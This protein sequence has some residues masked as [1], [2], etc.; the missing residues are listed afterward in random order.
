[1][2]LFDP[3]LAGQNHSVVEGTYSADTLGP[4]GDTAVYLGNGGLDTFI[5]TADA[6]E[7]F[8]INGD[9]QSGTSI[10]S[11][12]NTFTYVTDI[13]SIDV[14]ENASVT[15]TDTNITADAYT[16][17]FDFI[18]WVEIIGDDL[19][20]NI[21][22]PGFETYLGNSTAIVTGS[23]GADTIAASSLRTS[24]AAMEMIVYTAAVVMIF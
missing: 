21:T 18:R 6:F 22:T 24:A 23:Q 3:L 11:P 9:Y 19:T 16:V 2:P 10:T 20:V 12:L 8:Y 1:M 17:Y 4:S 7:I 13:L 14:R 15:L 5:G